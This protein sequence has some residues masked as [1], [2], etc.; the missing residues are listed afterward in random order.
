[1]LFDELEKGN[2]EVFNILL[3]ILEEWSLTD[4]KWRKINFKNTIIIMTSNIWWEEFN[5]KASQIWFNLSTSKEVKII[6]DYEKIKEKVIWNLEEYFPPEFL[7]RIDKTIVFNPLDKKI[8]RK[9]IELQ[10]SW[11]QKRL[12]EVSLKLEYDKKSLDLINEDT[13]NPEYGAR[14]VRRYLQEKIEDEI[15]NLLI[16]KKINGTIHMTAEKKKLI[17][18]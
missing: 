16:N 4:A 1:V 8:L 7:N 3:Q 15:A 2:F 10:L 6:Q 13:Y 14:P 9:I 12:E 11:L 18:K 17:M 5:S